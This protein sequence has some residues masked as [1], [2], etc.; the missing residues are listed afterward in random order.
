MK[1]TFLGH[2][3]FLIETSGH[4]LLVDPFLRENPAA[5]IPPENVQCDHIL[6]SHGHEDHTADAAEI[7]KANNAT[8]IANYEIAQYFGA[9]GLTTHGL[10]P[11]GG[12]T[13]PF[14]RASLTPAIH[15]SSLNAG[16]NPL[17]MGVACGIV[18][19]ADDRRIYHAGD[20]AL[21]SDMKLI[22]RAGL[23]LAIVP[24]GDNFT[25][26]PAD[27]LDALDL[28]Q[29]KQAIPMHYNTWELIA[30][31][32]QSFSASA[33]ERGHAVTALAPGESLVLP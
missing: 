14:G 1:I 17:Y 3:C 19:E 20:T 31:D 29:A 9:Q 7:A 13:F 28:L 4:R 10:N 16:A 30:Q 32:A 24:I 21:F 15:T 6:I 11:G 26:G 27:A 33:T 2:S 22:G 8:I 23:D 25:M 5:A 18:I 12:F